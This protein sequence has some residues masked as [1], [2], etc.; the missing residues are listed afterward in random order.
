MSIESETW[1]LLLKCNYAHKYIPNIYSADGMQHYIKTQFNNWYV[2]L[3][4]IGTLC[5]YESG[6]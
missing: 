2:Q 1:V 6:H 5:G 4:N 3:L